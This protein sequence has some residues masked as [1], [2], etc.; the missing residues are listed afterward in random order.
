MSQDNQHWL[1]VYLVKYNIVEILIKFLYNKC[2]TGY[3]RERKNVLA[4]VTSCTKDKKKK[5]E[6]IISTNNYLMQLFER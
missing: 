6:K 1:G 4:G 2:D 5:L 3:Y